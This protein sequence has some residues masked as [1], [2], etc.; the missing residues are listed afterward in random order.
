MKHAYGNMSVCVTC[1]QDIQFF[2][3]RTWLDRGGNRSCVAY[4]E[5]GE[6]K[7]PKANA[8]HKPA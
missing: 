4:V 2:G 7:H 6:I 1:G 5:K 8:K 3:K